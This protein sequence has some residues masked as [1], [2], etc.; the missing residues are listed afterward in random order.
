MNHYPFGASMIIGGI[1]IISSCQGE[2]KSKEKSK[3]ESKSEAQETN[4]PT[5]RVAPR[6]PNAM[7]PLAG[8]MIGMDS[9]LNAMRESVMSDPA[10]SWENRQL[11]E[12]D[13]LGYEPTDSTMI[14]AHFLEWAPVYEQAVLD[15][16]QA[17]SAITF[18]AVVQQCSNCHVG[19]CPGP[20]TRIEKRRVEDI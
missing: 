14:N 17:P 8:A 18:N 6:Q 5:V 10:H 4:S 16:N 3:E 19:T 20:L 13:L 9:Q 12:F 15:F 1:L 11:A 7:S 2:T